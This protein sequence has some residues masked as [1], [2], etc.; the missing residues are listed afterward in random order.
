MREEA[1]STAVRS[2]QQPKAEQR[3]DAA[4]SPEQILFQLLGLVIAP[5]QVA[6]LDFPLGL[7]C[8]AGLRWLAQACQGVTS[9]K[10]LLVPPP[11]LSRVPPGM[12]W[13]CSGCR[14]LRS[15]SFWTASL[16]S[17]LVTRSGGEEGPHKSQ[18]Q[19]IYG[20]RSVRL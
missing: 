4:S 6:L 9:D 1:L 10:L 19:G 11:L 14:L 15:S 3:R 2:A 17:R 13:A 18:L 8:C 5:C 20:L 12:A 16:A 7:R